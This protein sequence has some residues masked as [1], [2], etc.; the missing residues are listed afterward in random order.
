MNQ[1]ELVQEQEFEQKHDQNKIN[2]RI[3]TANYLD[4]AE[5]EYK[6]SIE[7]INLDEEKKLDVNTRGGFIISEPQSIK[8]D[9]KAENGIFSTK[10]GQGLSDM[11]PFIDRYSCLCGKTMSKVNNGMICP[12]CG[13]PVKRVDDN[14]SKFGWIQIT[15]PYYVIHPNLYSAIEYMFGP[16]QS[17][18][19]E[20]RS[21]LYNIINYAGEVDQ[22]GKEVDYQSTIADQPFFGIGMIEFYNRFDEIM[23]F[24]LRKYPKKIDTYN[25]IMADRDKVFTQSIP[26]FTTHLRPFDVR[27]GNMYFEEVNA[28]YNMINNLVD[29]INKS[30]TTMSNKKKPKNKLLFDIQ[31]EVQKLYDEIVSI[32]S[33]KKG[34]LRQLIGGRFNFS[35]RSVIAQDPSLR[36]DQ[37]KLPYVALAIMLQQK[38][39]NILS[40][41]YNI[42][43]SEAYD[44]WFKG[45]T[46]PNPRIREI[47]MSIINYYP[48]G[49]PVIINRNPTIQFGLT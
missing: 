41:T 38:I 23:D 3:T 12:H 4:N 24:Y 36:V 2:L 16:G 21:K 27:D 5:Y 18:D 47:I 37:V 33:G 31:M 43:S 28:Y 30:D 46:T 13:Q 1:E 39:I 6:L 14:Y 15:K 42:R 7:K 48:E 11:N 8:K 17:S 22:D 32:M 35:S 40:R 25:M 34:R 49:L 26:V 19:K 9:L 45:V 29:K 10:F 20:K 44:I